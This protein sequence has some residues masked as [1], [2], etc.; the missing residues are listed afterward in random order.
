ME[1]GPMSNSK[2]WDSA[3]TFTARQNE[4]KKSASGS[5]G[6]SRSPYERL[7]PQ[8][9][10]IPGMCPDLPATTG[11][12]EPVSELFKK[13]DREKLLS[14]S[15][16]VD[17]IARQQLAEIV[18]VNFAMTNRISLPGDGVPDRIFAKRHPMVE[19]H[20]HHETHPHSHAPYS[21]ARN[22]PDLLR[23]A[24]PR[25]PSREKFVAMLRDLKQRAENAGHGDLV[26]D[27]DE[28][29]LVADCCEGARKCAELGI[30]P[31]TFLLARLTMQH[32]EA[33]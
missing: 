21:H 15:V 25:H 33:A 20:V 10:L 2:F 17:E 24:D 11:T 31:A 26:H 22:H 7:D 18:G 6:A 13:A 28:E 30:H 3:P 14:K 1:L 12:P 9:Q 27:F 4:L 32:S 19:Q 23:E 5:T 8:V 29:K 16:D